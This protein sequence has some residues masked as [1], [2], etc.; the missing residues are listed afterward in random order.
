MFLSE[1]RCDLFQEREALLWPFRSPWYKLGHTALYLW[2]KVN[3]QTTWDKETFS[4]YKEKCFSSFPLSLVK[5]SKTH[6][7]TGVQNKED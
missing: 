7:C 2:K 5:L 4:N 3:K 1:L 6:L